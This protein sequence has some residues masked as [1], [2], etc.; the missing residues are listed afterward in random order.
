[1]ATG[2]KV[3]LM[4]KTKLAHRH[5]YRQA[6]GSAE[7]AAA[8]SEGYG[9]PARTPRYQQPLASQEEAFAPPVY[10]VPPRT[11]GGAFFLPHRLLCYRAATPA[12]WAY[13]RAY[14]ALRP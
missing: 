3:A 2:R 5:Q 8:L 12:D 6:A 11:S 9:R 10:L 4:P 13:G 1:M 14:E 7:T